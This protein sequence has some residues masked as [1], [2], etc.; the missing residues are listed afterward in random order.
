MQLGFCKTHSTEEVP[1]SFVPVAST[2]AQSKESIAM[3][4]LNIQHT[5]DRVWHTALIGN[6]PSLD[7][8]PGLLKW[9]PSFLANRVAQIRVGNTCIIC[10]LLMEVP[11]GSPLSPSLFILFIQ[12]LLHQLSG[13]SDTR[14][15]AFADDT[16]PWW[17]LSR[18][19][20]NR[21]ISPD[22]GCRIGD[23]SHR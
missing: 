9:I 19:C 4:C 18:G 13:V 23:R 17:I 10:H 12:D 11:Q 20:C 14:S 3:L 8:P 22:L 16:I 5:Y 7:T 2:I 15:Q 21:E 1:W 6:L